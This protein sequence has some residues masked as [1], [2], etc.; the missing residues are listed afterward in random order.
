MK[1]NLLKL[2]D[3]EFIEY[4]LRAEALQMVAT[5]ISECHDLELCDAFQ[6]VSSIN[7]SE[8]NCHSFVCHRNGAMTQ[9]QIEVDLFSQFEVFKPKKVEFFKPK[10]EVV[11]FPFELN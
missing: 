2:R 6:D 3:G 11:L 5:R 7:Y 8:D 4:V 10:N 9:Y 1:Y